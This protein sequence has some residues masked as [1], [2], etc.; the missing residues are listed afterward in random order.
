MYSLQLWKTSDWIGFEPF[1]YVGEGVLESLQVSSMGRQVN[2]WDLY[3]SEVMIKVRKI[4]DKKEQEE[5]LRYVIDYLNNVLFINDD[6]LNTLPAKGQLSPTLEEMYN[7]P[8]HLHIDVISIFHS[9][10]IPPAMYD[11]L[12]R[13]IQFETGRG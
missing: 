10:R 12:N 6:A 8:D 3:G 11:Y 5:F 4:Y 13:M 7:T 2:I 1:K 9:L